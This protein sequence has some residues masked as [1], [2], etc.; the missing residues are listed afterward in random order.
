MTTS[1]R[2]RLLALLA[3]L[4]LGFGA[5]ACGDAE[6]G[7]GGGTVGGEG[8]AEVDEGIDGG[9]TDLDI[10]GDMGEESEE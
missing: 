2:Q 6:D 8:G 4:T 1:T 9:G 10:E 5:T 3:I 7:S